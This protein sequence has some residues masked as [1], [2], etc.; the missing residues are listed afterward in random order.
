MWTD[1]ASAPIRAA[2][3]LRERVPPAPAPPFLKGP[4]AFILHYL[5]VRR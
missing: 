5:G 3:R 2:N 4:T 1:F